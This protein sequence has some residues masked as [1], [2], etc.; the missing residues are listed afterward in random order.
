MSAGD[1]VKVVGRL[2][3]IS[4]NWATI[5]FGRGCVLVVT[6]F[7]TQIIEPST[8]LNYDVKPEAFDTFAI[9]SRAHFRRGFDDSG[10]A[11][12]IL[13]VEPPEPFMGTVGLEALPYEHVVLNNYFP[14][15]RPNFG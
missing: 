7:L 14:Y 15:G 3:G 10:F 8:L 13:L 4:A 12:T 11:K 1:P 6:P 5:D 2:R 9:K